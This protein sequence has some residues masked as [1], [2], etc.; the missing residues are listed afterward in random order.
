MK[1]LVRFSFRSHFLQVPT[2]VESTFLYITSKVFEC[3]T[4][5]HTMA[6][7]GRDLDDFEGKKINVQHN[8]NCR[9][10]I[11]VSPAEQEKRGLEALFFHWLK[12]ITNRLEALFFHW[13]KFITNTHIHCLLCA[14][15][16]LETNDI[17]PKVLLL[18]ITK[19]PRYTTHNA[20]SYCK[21]FNLNQG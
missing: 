9:H 8:F 18:N 17:E 12:F 5:N 16:T 14:S 20:E 2:E 6:E 3:F 21:S 15:C 11:Y 10:Q 1:S 19:S 7:V 4:Q 13:W